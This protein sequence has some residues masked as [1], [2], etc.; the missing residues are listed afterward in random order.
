[1]RFV[2]AS[3]ARADRLCFLVS[4]SRNANNYPKR[5]HKGQ[6]SS[7]LSHSGKKKWI[8]AS[9]HCTLCT[10]SALP[11]VR[12]R[13]L[14]ALGLGCFLEVLRAPHQLLVVL[15]WSAK[16]PALWRPH[17]RGPP[18]TPVMWGLMGRRTGLLLPRPHWL[19][20]VQ[21][22]SWPPVPG[23]R[24][25]LERPLGIRK[26]GFSGLLGTQLPGQREVIY[27]DAGTQC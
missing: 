5:H 6:N 27:A 24:H 25:F 20:P 9:L 8:F 21:R 7:G 26:A 10:T 12:R 4:S 17:F 11:A 14:A 3:Q 23:L 22:P 19:P 2:F 1:M 13:W 16:H 18:G 15:T